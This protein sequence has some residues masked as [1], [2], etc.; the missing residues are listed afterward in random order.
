MICKTCGA[1]I[2]NKGNCEYCDTVYFE[3][4]Q[5]QKAHPDE[6]EAA[7]QESIANDK[8]GK[9]TEILAFPAK[10]GMFIWSMV[11]LINLPQLKSIDHFEYICL[12]LFGLFIF[13]GIPQLISSM[14]YKRHKVDQEKKA[15]TRTKLTSA[16]KIVAALWILCSIVIL[17]SVENTNDY[18]QAVWVIIFG[19]LFYGGL[20]QMISSRLQR[21]HKSNHAEQTAP[22]R[23]RDAALSSKL[24]DHT[25][26][27]ELFSCDSFE[28]NGFTEIST[29]KISGGSRLREQ[30]MFNQFT[31][32]T[33]FRIH[34][35]NLS[36]KPYD[37]MDHSEFELFCCDL[38]DKNEF[39]GISLTKTPEDQG[40]DIIAF[41]NGTKYGI[42]CKCVASI[43]GIATLQ[44]VLAGKSYFECH[45]AADIT[46]QYFS[47]DAKVLA[48]REEMMLWD[49][50]C[51][52]KFISDI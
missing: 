19:F 49:R 7:K 9:T 4:V 20:T 25:D 16:T 11:C 26:N 1:D 17:L 18:D 24:Y 28:K 42:Q 34:N 50:D 51:L 48:E 38:L 44:K 46:N 30:H 6:N 43:I 3:E 5:R 47:E 37:H 36:P 8:S 23:I 2:G 27:S 33:H 22:S 41:K 13:G 12:I 39:T 40:I 45:V 15:K 31:Q 35:A 52:N 21:R 29:T 14:L 10:I 32:T